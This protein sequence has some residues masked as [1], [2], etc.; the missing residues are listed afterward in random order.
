[1]HIPAAN[2]LSE[3]VLEIEGGF[4]ARES[5]ATGQS[6]LEGVEGPGR[7]VSALE[8]D[9]G[10]SGEEEEV[11]RGACDIWPLAPAWSPGQ[12]VANSDV[13]AQ[14]PHLNCIKDIVN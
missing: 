5:P 14:T 1:M 3:S 6:S 2:S 7:G 12:G 9:G 10:G 8:G 4:P 11:G 13:V